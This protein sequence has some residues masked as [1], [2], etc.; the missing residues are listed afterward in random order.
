MKARWFW[1]LLI[2]GFLLGACKPTIEEEPF[3]E[4]IPTFSQDELLETAA[5]QLTYA[6]HETQLHQPTATPTPIFTATYTPW[7]TV[8][9]TIART[10][11]S[12]A[13]PTSPTECNRAGMGVPFDVT[14]PDNTRFYAGE[15]FTKTWRLVNSGSCKWTRLYKLVFYS[16]NAMGA[17][18]ERFLEGEVLPGQAIDLSIRFTAPESPGTYQGNWM[19]QDPDGH[20]FGLGMNADSPFYVRIVVTDDPT[21]TPP[22][23]ETQE[24][25]PTP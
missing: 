6:H 22:A 18:Y 8:I 16:Q 25:S 1:S 11:T 23:N 4:S 5:M 24:P 19:L 7:P 14:V 2:L 20:L 15:S 12:D 17:Q 3:G 9:A 21:P 10:P 13:T